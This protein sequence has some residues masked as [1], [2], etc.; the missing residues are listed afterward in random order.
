VFGREVPGILLASVNDTIL[1]QGSIQ[2]LDLIF[3]IQNTNRLDLIF[4]SIDPSLPA[5]IK[6]IFYNNLGIE[7]FIYQGV[8]VNDH[9]QK[10]SSLTHINQNGLWYYEFSKSLAK[11]I[12]KA[13]T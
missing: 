2:D 6:E 1:Y 5:D 9:G 11:E 3:D 13:N 8:F 12:I 4:S 7:H 10:I